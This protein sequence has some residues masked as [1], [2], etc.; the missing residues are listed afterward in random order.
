MK[1]RLLHDEYNRR[2]KLQFTQ[3]L[4]ALFKQR[5]HTSK[6]AKIIKGDILTIRLICSFSFC[7]LLQNSRSDLLFDLVVIRPLFRCQ[8]F[9]FSLLLLLLLLLLVVVVVVV[10]VK[11]KRLE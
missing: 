3:M 5:A 6:T 11:M 10:V 7:R 4:S 8:F 1:K 9:P 2:K